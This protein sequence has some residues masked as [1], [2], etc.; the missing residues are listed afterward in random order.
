MRNW[1]LWIMALFLSALALP[2][3]SQPTC[4]RDLDAFYERA[5][6]PPSLQS[7]PDASR[8]ST[9]PDMNPPM[10]VDDVDREPRYVTLSECIA[11][12]LEKGTTGTISARQ[13]FS[14]NLALNNL[15][16]TTE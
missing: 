4:L 9:V 5:G 6:V 8:K 3:C 11:L 14:G 10:T 1:K 12:A 13:F 16:N 2:G 15:F 7:D